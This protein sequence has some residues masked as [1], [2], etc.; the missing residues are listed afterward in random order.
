MLIEL[1]HQSATGEESKP[2]AGLLSCKSGEGFTLFKKLAGDLSRSFPITSLPTYFSGES[3]LCLKS[4]K[5]AHATYNCNARFL[6][7][8]HSRKTGGGLCDDALI[9]DAGFR[10]GDSYCEL[11]FPI[12][13]DPCDSSNKPCVF[14][15][16]KNVLNSR[17]FWAF[18]D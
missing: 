1:C 15:L 2:V 9:Y 16:K 12:D 14:L 11:R 8:H 18:F 3:H 4:H 13:S 5:Y 6:K 7:S 10:T 17:S